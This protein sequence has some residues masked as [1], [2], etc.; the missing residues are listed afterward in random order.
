MR[1]REIASFFFKH[2]FAL[3]DQDDSEV[4]S[5]ALDYQDVKLKMMLRPG[6]FRPPQHIYLARGRPPRPRWSA[7]PGPVTAARSLLISLSVSL[8]FRLRSACTEFRTRFR[9]PAVRN[10]APLFRTQSA[11][12]FAFRVGLSGAGQGSGSLRS[13]VRT[14][15]ETPAIPFLSPPIYSPS[16][17]RMVGSQQK[18][19][20]SALATTPISS[21]RPFSVSG[22]PVEI[23]S[24]AAS[25]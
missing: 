1:S 14:A 15:C 12:C 22:I 4:L 19:S 20:L 13:V 17:V 18:A 5:D 9:S 16:P 3:P 11:P 25:K 10:S 24:Q 23:L 6:P 21:R 2:G 8:F 7:I